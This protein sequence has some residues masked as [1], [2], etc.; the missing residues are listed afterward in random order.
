MPRHGQLKWS[1][2][3]VGLVVTVALVMVVIAIMN[4][5][6]GLN[7]IN[8]QPE[9]RALVDHTQGLKVGGPVRMNGVD[10]GNVRSIGIAKDSNAVEI[11][12]SVHRTVLP[13][14]REDATVNI[15]PLGLLGDKYLD[16]APGSANKAA[17]PSN[18]VLHGHAEADFTGLASGAENTLDR[19][20]TAIGDLQRILT[21]V[22]DGQGTVGKLVTDASLYDR[23]Q[24][25]MEKLESI[26][27]K[28][29]D[30]LDRV[31]RGEGTIGKLV[32]NDEFYRRASRAL[33][34]LSQLAGR[35]NNQD[36]TLSKLSDPTL[37]H[38]LDYLT[39]RGEEL[40]NKIQNG[41]GTIGKLVNQDEL[42]IRSEKL[43]T[44]LETL[45]ADVRKN[46]TKYFK[47]S[48]F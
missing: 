19:L 3:K 27:E 28:S 12:F 2:L 11:V 6:H 5:S 22:S 35:L 16:L 48:L 39:K 15:R 4:M 42:Y 7:F 43:L 34:D 45:V 31:E 32:S 1:E 41:D 37:Y 40:L 44:E 14:L 21:K 30:V 38:R 9:L 25:V 17:L 10:V 26:S 33:N 18:Q 24:R 20:N 8:R 29:I 23:S 13:H 46:P 36:G 47:L